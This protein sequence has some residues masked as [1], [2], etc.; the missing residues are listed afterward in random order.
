MTRLVDELQSEAF[1]NARP[2]VQAAYTH[3]A[4]VAI[5]PFA[6]GNGR[7]ARALASVYLY[8][9][10]R[11]PLVIFADD[12]AAYFD[13]LATADKGAYQPFTDFIADAGIAT[14]ELVT[15]SL[16]TS[17]IP[18]PQET[19]EQ[20]RELLTVQGDLTYTDIDVVA[21]GILSPLQVA[22]NEEIAELNPPGG[23][24]VSMS[25]GNDT[26][27]GPPDGYR[28]VLSAPG[29]YVGINFSAPA[30]SQASRE[31]RFYVFVSRS[32]EED[33]ELF[34]VLRIGSEDGVTFSLRDVHPRLTTAAEQ[35]LRLLARRVIA[36][37]LGE[38]LAET[39]RSLIASGYVLD[40]PDA[41]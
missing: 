2:L 8:R 38:L 14:V 27:V 25:G 34:W 21:N 4:F 19:V 32:R 15:D 16:R 13:A 12:R 26:N 28:A 24:Q 41:E 9:A 36:K 7:V 10:A 6:D 5:H 31:A 20:F 29:Q 37:E 11:L 18:S 17:A 23:V 39:R 35:R 3:Y 30:P 33:A 22:I 40:E 1:E